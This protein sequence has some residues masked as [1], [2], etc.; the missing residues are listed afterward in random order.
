MRR[1]TIGKLAVVVADDQLTL[2][3]MIKLPVPCRTVNTAAVAEAQIDKSRCDPPGG[4]V[5][6]DVESVRLT[7][8]GNGF[9][10]KEVLLNSEYLE[11]AA[12]QCEE[13]PFAGIDA[14]KGYLAERGRIDVAT[15]EEL[16]DLLIGQYDVDCVG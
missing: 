16:V 10:I 6:D 9:G 7:F 2:V 4:Q 5:A 12:G 13:P 15:L 3:K 1:G 8:T 11:R 14:V